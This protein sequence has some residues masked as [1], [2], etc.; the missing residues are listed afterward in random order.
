MGDIEDA[1][2]E[3][4]VCWDNTNLVD[5]VT[6]YIP[7]DWPARKVRICLAITKEGSYTLAMPDY[8]PDAPRELRVYNSKVGNANSS[9]RF[10]SPDGTAI[11]ASSASS[12]S[13]REVD[14]FYTPGTGWISVATAISGL[15]M[16]SGTLPADTTFLPTTNNPVA[17]Q[18]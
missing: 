13:R 17:T 14:Y 18:E 11:A 15:S 4:W 3:Y 9:V 12:V 16:P 8:A 2:G 7:T 6:N 1:T 5:G 10:V